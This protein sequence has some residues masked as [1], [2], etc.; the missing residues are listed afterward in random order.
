[1]LEEFKNAFNRPN[2][3]HVQLILI[4]V[5]VFLVLA[6]LFVFSTVSGFKESFNILH[7]QFSIPPVFSEFITRPWTIITYAFAHSFDI[8]HI[9]FNM[10]ALYWFGKLFVE[11]LGSDKLTALYIL[12]AL[13]AGIVYLLVFNTIPFFKDRAATF[14]GM[15]GASG[16]VYAIMVAT[17]TLLPDYTFFLLFLGPVR[18]KYIAAFYIVLSFLGSVG[19][20]AG[21]NIAHLGGAF[22]GYL[23]IKQLQAGVNW[24]GWI[25]ATLEWFSGWFKPSAKVKVTYRKES[26]R[27]DQA[28]KFSKATQDEIDAILDKISDKGYESLSKDEKEK[29]FNASRKN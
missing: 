29:L 19:G 16:A 4:N 17:A 18:I 8:W 20:N 13:A 3:S 21:G 7:H 26:P 15:V 10:L 14:D 24:G 6:V 27:K 23:Y 25:T 22:M 1:M 28:T 11:Y 2:N 12:G 5:A 9:V